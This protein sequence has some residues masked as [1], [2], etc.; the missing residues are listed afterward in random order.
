MAVFKIGNVDFS[1]HVIAGTYSIKN[2]DVFATWDDGDGRTHKKLKR[3][4]MRGSFE[5]FFKT[6]EDYESFVDAIESGKTASSSAF[7]EATLTDNYSNDDISSNYYFDFSP[8]RN[9]AANWD[10]YMM[11]FTVNVEEY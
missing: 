10:D 8:V 1:G 6:M 2:V 9:R 11:R 7:V 3:T 5:M 4:Q